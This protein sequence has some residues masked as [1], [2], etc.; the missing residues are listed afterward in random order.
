MELILENLPQVDKRLSTL[1]TEMK[2]TSISF[3]QNKLISDI[4]SLGRLILKGYKI[5]CPTGMRKVDFHSGM[6]KTLFTIDV[7]RGARI[8]GIFLNGYILLSDYNGKII[9]CDNKGT[10]IKELKIP[11]KPSDIT[12]V[13]DLTVAVATDSKQ[14]QIINT[15]T[16]TLNK[17]ITTDV[18]IHGLSFVDNEYI[19]SYRDNT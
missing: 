11:E 9:K 16:L 8:S 5:K 17:R 7:V 15:Q 3:E 4:T 19:T 12:K 10:Q 18:N 6:F 1:T 2:N 13:D 14:I